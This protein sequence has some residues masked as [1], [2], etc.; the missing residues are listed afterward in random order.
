MFG[1]Q[2]QSRTG[3]REIVRFCVPPQ[4]GGAPSS[5]KGVTLTARGSPGDR[6]PLDAVDELR[7]QPRGFLDR[8]DVGD[9]AAQFVE[10]DPDLATSQVGAQAEMGTAP[11][12]AEMRVG[13]TCHVKSPRIGEL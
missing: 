12:E 4:A 7:Q 9:L 6:Q 11:A 8:D 13:V 1:E 2:T 5:R 10:G 3:S